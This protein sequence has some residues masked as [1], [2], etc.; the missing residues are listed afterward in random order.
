M[1][2]FLFGLLGLASIVAM[3]AWLI[4]TDQHL[5]I[6]F[7]HGVA[8][9][10]PL[11]D[12]VIIWTRT[13][14][15]QEADQPIVDWQISKAADMSNP[16]QAGK[17]IST[18]QT[19]HTVKID[20]VGLEP[21]TTYYYQF[22]CEGKTSPIGRTKT[23]PHDSVEEVQLAVVSCSNYEWGFFNPL[24]AL[25][26]RENIDAVL[27]L[28]D[29]IYEYGPGGYGDTT[30]GRI[31]QPPHEIITLHDYRMRYAQYRRTEGFR[32]V[33]QQHPFINIW[34]DHEITN[35]SYVEGAENHQPEEGD[36]YR[37]REAARRAYYEWMPIREAEGQVLYRHF[38]FG[39]LL[40]LLMLDERLAGRTVQVDSISDPSF[41]DSTRT[42]LGED[43]KA[44]FFQQ[45]D[46]SKATWKVIGNQVIFSDLRF[47]LIFPDRPLNLDAWDGYP[48]EKKQLI[49]HFQQQQIDNLIFVT[50]DTHCSWAFETPSSLE[51]YQSQGSESLVA[52]E[53]G[54]TSISS[55]NYNEYT[56]L[57]TTLQV[58]QVYQQSNPHLKY[59]NL[60][61]HGY[62]LLKLRPEE[63]IAEWY[64]SESLR[65]FSDAERL[66][67]RIKVAA[68]SRTLELE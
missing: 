11:S 16:L 55:G 5:D 2:N 34:D 42:M 40:D 41:A 68:G 12:R 52:V 61:E 33:H 67:K 57:D 6:S 26:K 59:V 56:S 60:H 53:F 13:S 47:D 63:A 22:A 46:Q 66:G 54:T 32:R 27:H 14:T 62:L 24:A 4:P 15:A 49:H 21:A 28:G 8:S 18:Y 51:D 10:D 64:Y 39:S 38:N 17:I 23:L 45:L 48:H 35:N 65:S 31:H 3:S 44:W 58:Q 29:Y 25:A 43:Q 1:K 7:A 9:G 30:I 20:V 36:Y 37:R 50:G 19:D